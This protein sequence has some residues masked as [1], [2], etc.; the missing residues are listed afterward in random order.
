MKI[1]EQDL[2]HGAAL[3]QIVEH[4]SFKALNKG[5]QNYGHYLINTDRHV[6][7]KYRK[8]SKSPWQF[9]LSPSEM[10]VIK[11]EA[12]KSQ[13]VYLCLVCGNVTICAL[14]FS[15]IQQLIDLNANSQQWIKVEVPR[16]GSCRVSGS[17]GKL[18]RTIAHKLFPDKVFS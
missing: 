18:K 12:Q 8:G 2:Y 17:K 6:Y 7:V 15:E 11:S 16:G 13:F 1:Q 9:T 14:D 5:S 10:A 4:E 3:T